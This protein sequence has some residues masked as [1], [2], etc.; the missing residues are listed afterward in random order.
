[1]WVVT[2][3]KY[4]IIGWV[5]PGSSLRRGWGVQLTAEPQLYHTGRVNVLPVDFRDTLPC[6][7]DSMV[8]ALMGGPGGYCYQNSTYGR[9]TR[10]YFKQQG[11]KLPCSWSQLRS[12]WLHC[13]GNW[14]HK[15]LGLSDQPTLYS[16]PFTVSS[17]AV[18]HYCFHIVTC[19]HFLFRLDFLCP[20][21]RKI[22]IKT[23]TQ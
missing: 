17:S 20:T 6:M 22:K 13:K 3:W 21:P 2:K 12:P 9:L 16:H 4:I 15:T 23:S 19:V 5:G 10:V 8:P 18:G 7:H 1:M 11:P 14:A